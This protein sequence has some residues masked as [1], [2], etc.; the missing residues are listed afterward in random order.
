MSKPMKKGTRVFLIILVV[1][2]LLGT[3]FTCVSIYAKKELEKPKFTVPEIEPD[4][5][6]TE[7]PEDAAQAVDCIMRLYSEAVSADDCVG[8]RHTEVSFDG[9]KTLPFGKA[10]NDIAELILN[11]SREGIGNLYPRQDDII[12]AEAVDMPEFSFDPAAVTDFAGSQG[13][14]N[15]DGSIRDAGF[16]FI[17]LTLDPGVIDAPDPGNSEIFKGAEEILAPLAQ[18]VDAELIPTGYKVTAKIDRTI[19]K[20]ISLDVTRSFT[21]NASLKMSDSLAALQ[22]DDLKVT[23]PYSAT[24]KINFKPY[25]AHFPDRYMVV[26]PGD[27][28][29]LPADVRVASEAT[30][31]DYELTFTP[32][33]PD[34]VRIDED[35]VMTV[36]KVKDEAITI[37]MVFKYD[38]H[39]YTDSLIVYITELEVDKNE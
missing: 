15:D 34:A 36:N 26:N 31:E 27:M 24:E 17:D 22:A 4:P 28:K 37:D 20:L 12:M 25:G 6:E 32:S 9:E 21:L 39:T 38:G 29:A 7:V 11:R 30:K 8:N 3:C 14:Q 18:V 1:I 16:Y 2:V 35:G 10:D 23:I 13:R 5:L 19:D 33:D